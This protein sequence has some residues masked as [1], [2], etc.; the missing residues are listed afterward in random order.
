[1]VYITLYYLPRKKP[2]SNWWFPPFKYFPLENHANPKW[3]T[4][5]NLTDKFVIQTHINEYVSAQV[6][7]MEDFNAYHSFFPMEVIATAE[8]DRKQSTPIQRNHF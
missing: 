7:R 6:L 3:L 5:N 2:K 8:R 4:R 1:M